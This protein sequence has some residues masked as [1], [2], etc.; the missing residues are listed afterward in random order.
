MSHHH[1]SSS[2]GGPSS[3]SSTAHGPPLLGGGGG[4]GKGLLGPAAA[5]ALRSSY[6]QD[7]CSRFPRLDQCAHFH[8]EYVELPPIQVGYRAGTL[9][10][11]Y[12]DVSLTVTWNCCLQ[13]LGIVA[14][15]YLELLLTVTWNCCFQLLGNSAYSYLEL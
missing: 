4:G 9:A 11:S 5:G 10:Y 2:L 8:Y 12:L 3:G 6:V 13:L 7:G 1:L 14:Y 15:S